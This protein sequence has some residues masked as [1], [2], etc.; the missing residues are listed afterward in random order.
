MFKINVSFPAARELIAIL[1]RTTG[2]DHAS[3]SAVADGAALVAM[4]AFALNVPVPTHVTEAVARLVVASHPESEDAP[5]LVRQFVRYGASP[6]GAQALIFGAKINAL[7][8]GRYNVSF[9][10]VAAVAANALRHRL[11]L[12]FEG[13]AE[14]VRTEALIEELLRTLKVTA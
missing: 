2:A 6:R 9:E 4:S 14:G 5:P 12:N 13:M 8:E 1:E 3:V 7:L 10:D 11:L